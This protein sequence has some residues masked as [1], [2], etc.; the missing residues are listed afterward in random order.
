MP[1]KK[2]AAPKK[3][4]KAAKLTDAVGRVYGA[5]V[6]TMQNVDDKTAAKLVTEHGFRLAE[7]GEDSN[8]LFA[9]KTAFDS[10]KAGGK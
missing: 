9:D 5:T 4:S 1:A 8:R 2:K 10:W 6:F 7:R 3:A